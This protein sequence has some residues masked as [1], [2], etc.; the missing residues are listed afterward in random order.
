MKIHIEDK[1][2]GCSGVHYRG[3]PLY[4]LVLEAEATKSGASGIFLVGMVLCDWL[5]SMQG[6]LSN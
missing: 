2:V 5:L 3:A 4:I 1:I 6:R